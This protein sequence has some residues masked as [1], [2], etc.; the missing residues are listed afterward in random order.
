VLLNEA[1]ARVSRLDTKASYIA[2]YSIG[3]I[4]LL[5]S[6]S[7][8]W[9]TRIHIIW[10]PIASGVVAFLSTIFAVVGLTLRSLQWFSGND[11]LRGECLEDL[12]RLKKYR[13]LGMLAV[14]NSWE[15]VARRK[16]RWIA[17]A[18]LVLVIAA[19]LL[20]IPIIDAARTL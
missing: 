14:V 5:V 19:L 13:V 10:L 3:I 12:D 17:I 16:A 7:S 6:T 4:T 9:A 15:L 2:A 11:W 8:G 18:Q 20:V 1:V